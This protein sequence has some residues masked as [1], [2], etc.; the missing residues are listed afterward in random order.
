MPKTASRKTSV[1]ATERVRL[2]L[3]DVAAALGVSRTTVSNAFNRPEQLSKDLRNQVL[4]KS[5]ELGYFGPDAKAR[6]LRRQ[7]TREVA[8]VFHHDLPYAFNDALSLDFMRGVAR[9]LHVRGLT[10]QLIPK[11]SRQIEPALDAAFNT[12]ADALIVHA[13]IGPE[14]A[15]LVQAAPMPLVLVDTM[16]PG[17]PSVCLDDRRGAEMAMAHALAARPDHVLV[18]CFLIA[19]KDMR[20]ALGARPARSPYNACERVT[21]FVQ[22]ARRA[23]FDESRILWL[24]VDDAEPESASRAVELVRSRLQKHRRVAVV[25]MSDRMALAAMAT[26]R[27]WSEIALVSVTGFDD[28]PAAAA[29]GL[30]TVRQDAIQKGETAV[31]IVLDG[32]PSAVLPLELV[33]R[34]T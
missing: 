9:Q 25:T 19:E 5:K 1:P 17:A 32:E 8:V 3:A 23:G 24:P 22:A 27:T 7:E 10:L 4:E 28:I 18:L 31:R 16:V 14:F 34:E 20:R 29:A 13:A 2:T 26:M 12:T 11:F 33:V 6:A 30:T 21:G 15:P